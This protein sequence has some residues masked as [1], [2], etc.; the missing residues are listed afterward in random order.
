MDYFQIFNPN[1]YNRNIYCFANWE[2]SEFR[3]RISAP[4]AW[5]QNPYDVSIFL[6]ARPNFKKKMKKNPEISS[7]NLTFFKVLP[8]QNARTYSN[9]F[10]WPYVFGYRL[11]TAKIFFEKSPLVLE[12]FRKKHEGVKITPQSYKD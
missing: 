8:F 4:T 7:R 2:G 6:H 3:K 5:Y 10:I 11:G 12:L 1:S 9:I